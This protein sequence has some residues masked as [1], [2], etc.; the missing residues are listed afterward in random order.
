MGRWG[1]K[2]Q[3]AGSLL[4]I[5]NNIFTIVFLWSLSLYFFM[6]FFPSENDNSYLFQCKVKFSNQ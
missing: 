4:L 6:T 3:N 1:M 2:D 5:V